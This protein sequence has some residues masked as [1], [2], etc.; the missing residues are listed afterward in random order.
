MCAKVVCVAICSPGNAPLFLKTYGMVDALQLHH[1]MYCAL[2]VCLEKLE[3]EQNPFK[4]K[5]FY[6]GPIYPFDDQKIHGY[7]TQTLTKIL[8]MFDRSDV[9]KALVEPFMREIH[10]VY[11][12]HFC[13]PFSKP[14]QKIESPTFTDK[15][16]KMVEFLDARLSPSGVH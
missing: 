2:D 16:N 7:I 5:S 6:Q 13:G 15:I 9:D 10:S 12:K 14:E 8:V 4:G 1:I 3:S 11:V